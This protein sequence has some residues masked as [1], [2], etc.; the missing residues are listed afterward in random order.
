MAINTLIKQREE[1]E[2]GFTLME[3][4]VV[5]AILGIL[6][7]IAIP[8]T[9]GVISWSKDAAYKAQNATMLEQLKIKIEQSGGVVNLNEH[10][11]AAFGAM[12][13]RVGSAVGELSNPT[14]GGWADGDWSGGFVFTDDANGDLALCAFTFKVEN[15]NPAE[16]TTGIYSR[17]SGD[18][19]CMGIGGPGNQTPGDPIE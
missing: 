7:A 12:M 14:T 10:G 5:V 6:L 17:Q 16:G 4:V 2:E 9:G 11:G 1:S 18:D 8:V 15:E 13:G 19:A 3:L